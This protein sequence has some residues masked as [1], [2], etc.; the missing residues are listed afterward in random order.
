MILLNVFK[1][2]QLGTL[3]AVLNEFLFLNLGIAHICISS[4]HNS[5]GSN[6]KSPY[7]KQTSH[8][9]ARNTPKHVTLLSRQ[10][11]EGSRGPQ[12]NDIMA[13]SPTSERHHASFY[14][15]KELSSSPQ[16]Q[17]S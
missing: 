15:I 16:Y 17:V 5:V 9:A 7:R 2:V 1:F 3:Y 8:H 11:R 14:G 4:P 12:V 6:G 13:L 10:S